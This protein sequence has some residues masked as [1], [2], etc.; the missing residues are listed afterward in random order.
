MRGHTF[1][2]NY[3]PWFGQAT[4]D[5]IERTVEDVWIDSGGGQ[6]HLS[7]FRH[8]D[9]AET[10]GTVVVS[11]CIAGY[12]LLIAPLGLRLMERG[13]NVVLPNLAGYGFNPRRRGDWTWAEFVQNFLG[14]LDAAQERYRKSLF[15]A[16][17]SQDGP[18]PYHAA[19][20][21]P[22]L[23]ALACYYLYDYR[24]TRFLADVSRFGVFTPLAQRVT[25]VGSL[26]AI[27]IGTG[28]TQY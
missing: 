6:I 16:G 2:H 1:W 15:L 24:D 9:P 12:G 3:A 17:M 13:F 25:G 26:R 8:P 20:H 27:E 28:V 11:H 19:C 10:I 23:A 14:T 5:T 18:L 4:I 22:D 7:L 21:R